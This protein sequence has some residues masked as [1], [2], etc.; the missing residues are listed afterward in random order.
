MKNNSKISKVGKYFQK[1][2][3][4]VV[5]IMTAILMSFV[6]MVCASW[7]YG[8][9]SNALYGTKFEINSCWQG[10]TILITGLGGIVAL[11]KAGY[12]GFKVDSIY[13]SRKGE[14]PYET[15][16]TE[17]TEEHSGKQP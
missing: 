11:A 16:D 1:N 13:N 10:F 8:Y 12:T 3:L 7:L 15:S 6:L 14:K 5:I 2:W 4:S 9:W 17:R